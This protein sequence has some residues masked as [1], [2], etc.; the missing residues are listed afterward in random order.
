[1][2]EEYCI[3]ITTFADNTN[4]KKIIEALISERLAACV[5]VIGG[6]D[7]LPIR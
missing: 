2:N 6:C 1:M 4:G 7:F 3:V 5:Q